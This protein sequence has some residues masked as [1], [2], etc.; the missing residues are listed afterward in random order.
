ML[1]TQLKETYSYNS[2]TGGFIRI[3]RTKNRLAGEIVGCLDKSTGYIK[4]GLG[5]KVYHA[6]RLA[7]LYIHGYLPN[8]VDHINGIRHDNRLCNL[9]ACSDRQ[10]SQNT[11]LRSDNTSGIKGL[12]YDSIR[13]VYVTQIYSN[14]VRYTRSFAPS[15]YGNKE[16]ALQEAINWLRD[17]RQQLHG[18]F[19]KHA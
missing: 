8:K 1:E 6:H 9:R 15:K 16:Q 14:N 3:K 4:L 12:G 7:W 5:L 17:I 19:C 2:I 18:E 13:K 11:N 10:N